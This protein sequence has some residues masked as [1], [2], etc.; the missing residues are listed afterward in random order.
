MLYA[1][2]A[3][4]LAQVGLQTWDQWLEQMYEGYG[5]IQQT[6]GQDSLLHSSKIHFG[7]VIADASMPLSLVLE[8]VWQA[9]MAAAQYS[10]SLP[11]FNGQCASVVQVRLL[12]NQGNTLTATAQLAAF[13]QWRSVIRQWQHSQSDLNL[14]ELEQFFQTL[15][16]TTP[17]EAYEQEAQNWLQLA[18]FHLR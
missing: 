5:Q 13:T 3:D 16:Q 4:V 6:E 10:R 8:Q 14:H 15:Q 18:V 7:L 11:T 17:P 1:C 9:R 2:D 12:E